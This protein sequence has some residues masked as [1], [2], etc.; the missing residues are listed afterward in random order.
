MKDGNF[1]AGYKLAKDREFSRRMNLEQE[2]KELRYEVIELKK[3]L[4]ESEAES[5][6]WEKAWRQEQG[7]IC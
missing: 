3:K 4:K 7:D 1:L 2:N 5:D 6:K